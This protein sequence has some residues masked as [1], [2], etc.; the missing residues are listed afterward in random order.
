MN[1]V[2]I[3]FKTFA[4][5]AAA[6]LVSLQGLDWTVE[7]FNASSSKLGLALVL[8][9]IGALVAVA[10][11]FVSSP[12]VS[13]LQKASRSAV[14]AIAGG[15]AAIVVNTWADV[16]TLPR[17]IVPIAVAAVLAFGVTFF[18]NQAPPVQPPGA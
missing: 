8:A 13:A 6:A 10:W 9:A 1:Y 12:A 5:L 4:Q 15:I 7:G 17:L 11:A 16:V 18:S 3:A 14:Q 2:Q